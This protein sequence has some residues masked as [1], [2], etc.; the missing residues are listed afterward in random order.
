MRNT[1][2]FAPARD[3]LIYQLHRVVNKVTCD[4]L[5]K[6]ARESSS[7]AAFQ[8]ELRKVPHWSNAQIDGLAKEVA[9]GKIKNIKALI[10]AI[11][12]AQTRVLTEHAA[13]AN[14]QS[15]IVLDLPEWK[16]VIHEVFRECCSE[17]Y[18]DPK[19]VHGVAE[20]HERQLRAKLLRL[21]FEITQQVVQEQLPMDAILTFTTQAPGAT[22]ALPPPA[23]DGSEFGSSDSSSSDSDDEGAEKTVGEQGAEQQQPQQPQ[24]PKPQ[25]QQEGFQ[26]YPQQPLPV[27]P[28]LPPERP[29]L[30]P[31]ASH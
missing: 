21:F 19:M 2:N 16:L 25:P 26:G 4:R 9:S 5:I 10:G 20:S 11:F 13:T 22:S 15:N 30:N 23:D 18:Y 6:M 12:V 24:Q 29:I 31:D 8:E 28:A 1:L 3:E 7:V 27:P 17:V 14:S